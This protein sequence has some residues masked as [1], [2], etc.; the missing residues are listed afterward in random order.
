[1][2]RERPHGRKRQ[3]RA[4][5]RRAMTTWGE[6]MGSSRLGRRVCLL[7]GLVLAGA[8]SAPAIAADN[9]ASATFMRI[10]QT[11][12][13]PSLAGF[14]TE[15]NEGLTQAPWCVQQTT[16]GTDNTDWTWVV[17]NGRRLTATLS[18]TWDNIMGLYPSNRTDWAL[19]NT[20]L[21]GAA[22]A[23]AW[24]SG[25]GAQYRIQVGGCLG[26]A[27]GAFS[28]DL[29]PGTYAMRV[30]SAP[31]PN[32]NRANARA[33]APTPTTA[34]QF[35][36]H[37]ASE[38]A[39]EDLTCDGAG[40]LRSTAWARY[41][42]PRH[43]K[44][45]I[46]AHSDTFDPL[47]A[48]IQVYRGGDA[49]PFTCAD[50]PDA[51]HPS[52]AFDTT[53]GAE[54]LIQIGVSTG[55][56]ALDLQGAFDLDL[57]FSTTDGDGDGD[58]DGSD[59]APDDPSRAHGTPDVFNN[60]VD[61]DCDGKDDKDFDGDGFD[62]KPAGPDC[63]DRNIKI[64]P[65]ASEI[66]GNRR[67][68]NCDGKRPAARLSPNPDIQLFSTLFPGRGRIFGDT[69]V[70][71]V[72]KR[73]KIVFKCKGAGCGSRDRK[74]IKVKKAGSVRTS[75]TSGAVLAPGA[76]FEIAVT[77]P[78]KNRIGEYQRNEVGPGNS[79]KTRTC[80]LAP[81]SVA[82]RAFKRVRCSSR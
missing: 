67:D 55:A 53:T 20:Q 57:Q 48:V 79:A 29:N 3:P 2:P 10:G 25:L 13:S 59:C 21:S 64:S 11:Y 38:E 30:T 77:L 39:D 19:C 27:S 15:A 63:N 54:Y 4:L 36:L 69:R 82:G 37:S 70:A 23:L 68:E 56:A 76:R 42:A 65:R 49:A 5:F 18:A 45:V 41:V 75:W 73:Y 52:V 71:N 51:G 33:V 44:A 50:P 28:C 26:D 61:E 31:P 12:A 9:Y 16:F 78:R 72:G 14:G 81:K 17:G 32:D 43:G 8:W 74:V 6:I 34:D 60:N 1:M 24:D 62:F 66:A 58:G 22:N 7:L 47:N 40:A 35:D 46:T 80:D